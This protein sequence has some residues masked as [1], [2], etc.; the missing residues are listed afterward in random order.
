MG[1]AQVGLG[2]ADTGGM[3]SGEANSHYVKRVVLP[4]GKRIEVVYFKDPVDQAT[5]FREATEP[6]QDLSACAACSSELVYPVDW[7]EAET[8]TWRVQLRCPECESRREGV[9]TQD[10]VERFDEAL[11]EGTDA[12]TADYR[13]L[14]RANMVEEIARFTAALDA[15]AILPEDF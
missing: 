8:D 7:E 12:L 13:R 6:E 14:S 2:R 9:F 1:S 10:T 11:D 4:S 3:E 15:G 5:S